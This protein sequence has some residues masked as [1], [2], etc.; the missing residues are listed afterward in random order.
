[1]DS[2]SIFWPRRQF[3]C[4]ASASVAGLILPPSAHALQ[5][6]ER[7]DLM[8]AFAQEG[9]IGTFALYEPAAE[10]LSL[11]DAKR[12]VTRFVPASTFKI[13]N[14]LIALET[15]VVKDEYEIIPF[16]G[17]PQ[18]V[19]AWERDMSMREAIK[20]SAV[21]I[22]QELARRIGL[23]R[24]TTW[25]AKLDYGNRMTGVAVERFWLDGPLAISAV[26]QAL[27]VAQ[28]AQNKLP[29]SGRSQSIVRDIIR[30]EDK[31]GRVLYGK[32]G[33]SQKIGW[34][35]GWVDDNG[36]IAAFAVNMDMPTI[37]GAP[38]RN[39]IARAILGQLGLY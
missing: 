21:P 23:E 31:G 17:Q 22:Y 34:L 36:R 26:E 25:L 2:R 4:L 15:G 3:L 6:V 33:W 29:L 27:F 37:S 9:A 38:K 7:S 35:A 28:L 18:A 8:T 11:V 24:Y 19:K 32:T 13:A 20:I 10:R 30:Q 1:M 5:P 39:T 12:A 14:S 16:G